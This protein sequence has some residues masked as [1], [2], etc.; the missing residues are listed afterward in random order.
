MFDLLK[1]T[2]LATAI[3]AAIVIM[4]ETIPMGSA[5]A[6]QMGREGYSF[7]PRNSSLAAQFQFQ[8]SV[9]T[10]AQGSSDAALGALTQYSNVYNSSSTAI[11]NMN[12]VTQ[13]LSGG[14]TGSVDTL[15]SQ[16][17]AGD[18]GSTAKTDVSV[19]NSVKDAGNLTQILTPTVPETPE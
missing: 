6:Q 3:S 9:G 2:T 7:P 12:S 10:S 1:I 18:Q 19:D 16:D 13:N 5:S 15:G 11:A 17:S 4:A 14:S 8:C